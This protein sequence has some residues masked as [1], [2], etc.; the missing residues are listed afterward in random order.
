MFMSY[1]HLNLEEREKL[2][3]LKSQG[4]SLQK[5][6]KRLGRSAGTLSRELK[7]NAKYGVAYI[8]CRAQKLSDKRG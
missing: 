5:I 7:R 3:A 4:I 8:P 1:K 2:Y 6:S